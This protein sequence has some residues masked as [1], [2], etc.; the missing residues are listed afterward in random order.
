MMGND[1][2]GQN[3]Q[4]GK[5][6]KRKPD[7]VLQHELPSLKPTIKTAGPSTEPALHLQAIVAEIHNRQLVKRCVF[8]AF[9]AL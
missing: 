6:R 1:R 8:S 2:N 4:Y 7:G 3:S 5:Y 9:R